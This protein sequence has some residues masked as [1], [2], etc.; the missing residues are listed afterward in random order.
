M[1]F[2]SIRTDD[3]FTRLTDIILTV[4]SY[5]KNVP[6]GIET[7]SNSSTVSKFLSLEAT[8]RDSALKDSYDQWLGVGMFGRAGILAQLDPDAS[9][10]RK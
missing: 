5:F 4:Q 7:L 1:K 9:V 3:P 2:I 8:F 6:R 10:P